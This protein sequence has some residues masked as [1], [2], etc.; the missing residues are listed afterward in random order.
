MVT[1]LESG[2]LD[3]FKAPL[4]DWNWI[5]HN[6]F[7]F[8]QSILRAFAKVDGAFLLGAICSV[9]LRRIPLQLDLHGI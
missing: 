5:N 2:L 8:E 4:H 6:A 7:D 3:L 1:W 9:D